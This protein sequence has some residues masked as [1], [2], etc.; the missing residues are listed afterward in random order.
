MNKKARLYANNIF[1]G[2]TRV[3]DSQQKSNQKKILNK[4]AE[5]R[6][7]INILLEKSPEKNQK[8][9]SGINKSKITKQEKN[10]YNS[11]RNEQTQKVKEYTNTIEAQEKKEEN[12]KSLLMRGGKENRLK[13]IKFF[14]LIFLLLLL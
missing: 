2:A 1:Y 13:N 6:K 10:I 9:K 5:R 11:S 4:S 12:I 14:N 7:K 3:K 8:L